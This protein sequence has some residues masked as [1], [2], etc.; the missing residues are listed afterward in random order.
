[1]KL[2]LENSAAQ[3]TFIPE[4]NIFLHPHIS[5]SSWKEVLSTEGTFQF[6]S[7]KQK[8]KI[9]VQSYFDI[10]SAGE[11]SGS[12][13]EAPCSPEPL[14]SSLHCKIKLQQQQRLQGYVHTQNRVCKIHQ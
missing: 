4:Q 14:P 6:N 9:V 8:Q 3:Q 10:Q 1:M 5:R 2:F 7:N 12:R 13:V 11:P